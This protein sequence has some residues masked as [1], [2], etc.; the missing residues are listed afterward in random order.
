MEYKEAIN[1]FQGTEREV[2]DARSTALSDSFGSKMKNAVGMEGLKSEFDHLKST[3]IE[4]KMKNAS[5]ADFVIMGT[6]LAQIAPIV[7]DIG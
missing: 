4:Q 1:T 3:E 6:Q 5:L 7:G 2:R